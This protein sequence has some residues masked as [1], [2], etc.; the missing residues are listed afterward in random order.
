YNLSVPPV[1][2]GRV[3]TEQVRVPSP[4]SDYQ[5]GGPEMWSGVKIFFGACIVL[6]ILVLIFLFVVVPFLS[7]LSNGSGQ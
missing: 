5:R 3:E 1:R 4:P 2:K 7:G 6:T